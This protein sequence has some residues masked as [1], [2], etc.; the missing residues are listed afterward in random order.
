MPRRS[1]GQALDAIALHHIAK[2]SVAGFIQSVAKF[3]RQRL[4]LPADA[5]PALHG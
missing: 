5:R 2:E 1:V 3:L 4:S